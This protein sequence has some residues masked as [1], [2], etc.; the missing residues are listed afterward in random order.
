MD[1]TTTK[2]TTQYF[3]GLKTRGMAMALVRRTKLRQKTPL[4]SY[5]PLNPISEKTAEL[6]RLWLARVLRLARTRAKWHCEICG[7]HVIFVGAFG[8]SGHHIVPRARGRIDTDDNCIIGCH[9][10]H[11]HTQYA[12][13]IP[14]SQEEAQRI[15]ST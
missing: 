13:G 5:K 1:D 8:L 2:Y 14:M 7:E 11:D 6:N 9:K 15:I 12:E 3:A 4:K 10:C